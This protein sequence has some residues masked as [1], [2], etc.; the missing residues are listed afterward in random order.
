MRLVR[1]RR[2]PARGPLTGAVGHV[3]A[4]PV[5]QAAMICI[6]GSHHLCEQCTPQ[7]N[8][9]RP[10]A[11]GVRSHGIPCCLLAQYVVLSGYRVPLHVGP[12][13]GSTLLGAMARATMLLVVAPPA[14][15]AWWPGARTL[16]D[17]VLR[18]L[19]RVAQPTRVARL[20]PTGALVVAIPVDGGRPVP[21]RRSRA[22]LG[23]VL[24]A[25][26]WGEPRVPFAGVTVTTCQVPGHW[27]RSE[28]HTADVI[29]MPMA[30]ATAVVPA[31]P[32]AGDH[33][34]VPSTTAAAVDACRSAAATR[35][36]P[37]S[38]D[39]RR[40]V[41]SSRSLPSRPPPAPRATRLQA[42]APWSR[43]PR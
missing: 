19:P 17:S 35:T 5:R 38:G 29:A 4:S 13:E 24:D 39:P 16:P 8:S 6:H 40:G 26:P 31:P 22:A 34:P 20:L 18:R 27:L 36:P 43:E 1:C 15:V 37:A 30:R 23:P 14:P 21:S 10:A 2:Q 9:H 25:A 11:S 7:C 12:S 33:H 42:P 41:W 32:S 3:P 28:A